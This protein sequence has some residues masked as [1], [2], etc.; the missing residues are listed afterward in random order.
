M[1]MDVMSGENSALPPVTYHL[2]TS[3]GSGTSDARDSHGLLAEDTYFR[4][5]VHHFDPEI[6]VYATIYAFEWSAVD[7]ESRMRYHYKV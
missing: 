7:S 1:S 3:I 4:P 6:S 2:T 5:P